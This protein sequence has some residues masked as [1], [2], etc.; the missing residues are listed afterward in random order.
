M[1]RGIP[2]G[3][4]DSDTLRM[5]LC[6]DKIKVRSCIG[7]DNKFLGKMGRIVVRRRNFSSPHMYVYEIKFFNAGLNHAIMGTVDGFV[8][9]NLEVI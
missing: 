7:V 3:Q 9:E 2:S 8:E 4:F 5:I 6:G 1:L